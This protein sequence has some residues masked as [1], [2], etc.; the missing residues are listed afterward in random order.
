MEGPANEESESMRVS[1]HDGKR[2][3]RGKTERANE[4]EDGTR[5]TVQALKMHDRNPLRKGIAIKHC[6][7][8]YLVQTHPKYRFVNDAVINAFMCNLSQAKQNIIAV[9]LQLYHQVAEV[10][11]WDKYIKQ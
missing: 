9:S 1:E 3:K 7:E 8:Q 4:T 6:V 2:M 5:S 10:S 11:G